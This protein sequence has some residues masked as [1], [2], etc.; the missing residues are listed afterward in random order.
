MSDWE[1]YQKTSKSRAMLYRKVGKRGDM[2]AHI[3]DL[4]QMSF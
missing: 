1:L 3:T 2:K 4:Q